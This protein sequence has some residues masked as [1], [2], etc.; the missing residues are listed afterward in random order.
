LLK[1]SVY[2]A[3]GLSAAV[4]HGQLDFDGFLRTTLVPEVQ[5]QQPGYNILRRRIAIVIGQWIV[6]ENMDHTL[7]YQIFQFLLNKDDAMN[8]LVVRVTAGRQLKTAFDNYNVQ[9]DKFLPF[10][11]DILGKLLALIQEL[12]LADTKM[13][14]LNTVRAVVVNMEH[15]VS[16]ASTFTSLHTG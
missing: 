1:D 10:A 3:I 11:E 13:A 7:V 6:M 8:D 12:D 15:H 5:I 9:V 16:L 4:L 14:L 2:A